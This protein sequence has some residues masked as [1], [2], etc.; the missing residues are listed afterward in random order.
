MVSPS[1]TPSASE[2]LGSDLARTSAEAEQ[3]ENPRFWAA[4]AVALLALAAAGFLAWRWRQ[5]RRA[6]LAEEERARQPQVTVAGAVPPPPPPA[7]AG[8]VADRPASDV[9]TFWTPSRP[10]GPATEF[11]ADEPP[12]PPPP[13]LRPRITMALHPRRAGIN[14]VSATADLELTVRNEGDGAAEAVAVSLRLLAGRAGQDEELGALFG[15]EQ[16]RPVLP[17]FA[18]APGEER[19]CRTTLVLPRAEIEPI[20]IKGRPMFVPVVAADVRYLRPDGGRGQTAA[21]FVIRAA[22]PGS[23]TLAPLWLDVGSK[24]RDDVE[25]RPHGLAIES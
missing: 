8:A 11:A 19:V 17:P 25:A 14:L 2:S 7:E 5:A 4:I 10:I 12:A 16:D 3:V 18:L 9:P 13:P 20:P 23:E 1:P 24:M 22:R 21:A 6:R 15:T